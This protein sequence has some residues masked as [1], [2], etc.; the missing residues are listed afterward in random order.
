[1]KEKQP[2]DSVSKIKMEQ[3]IKKFIVTRETTVEN[4]VKI[5]ENISNVVKIDATG[6][7]FFI[8]ETLPRKK[9]IVGI[10]LARYL[11]YEINKITGEEKIKNIGKN[12]S[13]NVIYEMLHIEGEQNKKS[14]RAMLTQLIKEGVVAR[15]GKGEYTIAN[16]EKAKRYLLNEVKK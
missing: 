2:S 12:T 8:N 15:I 13:L 7:I 5:I 14:V 9:K 3:A 1:M 16:L 10:L 6:N 4:L 11:A